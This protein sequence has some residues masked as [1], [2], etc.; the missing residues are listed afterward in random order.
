MKAW[1]IMKFNV[2]TNHYLVSLSFFHEDPYINARAQAINVH[3]SFILIYLPPRV[4]TRIQIPK[5]NKLGL[6]WA[7]LSS[8]W[9]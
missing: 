4:I 8:S 2:V 9:Y 6:S 7:K 3:A 1:I 5:S